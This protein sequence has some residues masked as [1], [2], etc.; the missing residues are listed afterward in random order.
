M[1]RTL[2]R[3]AAFAALAF[4]SASASAQ[5]ECETEFYNHNGS[6]MRGERCGASLTIL[7]E[8]PRQGIYAQGVTPGTV[9]FEGTIGN[10]GAVEYIEG[11]ARVFKAR[12][13]DALFPVEGGF[14][15]GGAA[16]R[17]GIYLAG[18][19]PVRA[20]NCAITGGRNET[21]QFD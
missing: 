11:L 16:G 5:V 3:L 18:V 2:P 7:Y 10:N 13:P 17:P 9:L 20:G 15:P 19:A 4:W 12:C 14:T 21:L 8:R 6:Q 1:L